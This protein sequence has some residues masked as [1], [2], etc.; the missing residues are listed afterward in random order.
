M[1]NAKATSQ[2]D[3][4]MKLIDHELF[5]GHRVSLNQIRFAFGS[6]MSRKK[7][8]ASVYLLL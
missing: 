1:Q 6:I 7:R 5:Q 2:T 3:K 4:M 8:L